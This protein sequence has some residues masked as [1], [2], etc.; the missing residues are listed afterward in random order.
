MT[1]RVLFTCGNPIPIL[2]M[3]HFEEDLVEALKEIVRD[4]NWQCVGDKSN[5]KAPCTK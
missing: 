1:I 2:C 3:D 4:G 5:F